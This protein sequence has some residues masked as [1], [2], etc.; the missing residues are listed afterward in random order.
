MMDT[1]IKDEDTEAFYNDIALPPFPLLDTVPRT[2]SDAA[3][4]AAYVSKVDFVVQNV[5]EAPGDSTTQQQGQFAGSSSSSSSTMA[6]QV[7]RTPPDSTGTPSYATNGSLT[8]TQSTSTSYSGSAAIPPAVSTAASL[9]QQRHLGNPLKQAS[10]MSSGAPRLQ[11][12][13]G[14]EAAGAAADASSGTYTA[15]LSG[16][17]SLQQ[18]QGIEDFSGRVGSFVP[19][20]AQSMPSAPPR[21]ALDNSNRL[22]A[23]RGYNSTESAAI[24][25]REASPFA[26]SQLQAMYLAARRKVFGRTAPWPEFYQLSSFER[27]ATGAVAV[28]RVE[29][30]VRFFFMNYVLLCSVLAVLAVIINPAILIVGAVFGGAAAAAGLHGGST[31][32]VGEGTVVPVK[33]IRYACV[34][35]G[36][37]T[38]LFVAGQLVIGL[39]AVCAVLVL[40]HA[41]L[42]VGV[43]YEKIAQHSADDIDCGV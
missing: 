42:H 38:L 15:D 28:D 8:P 25:R 4:S 20:A 37:L 13:P 12:A 33:N 11:L 36:L 40:L 29:R 3:S 7:N 18:Q 22:A 21:G 24:G 5:S 43:S 31:I 2:S 16:S 39:L 34:S 1:I 27:P 23:A 17:V 10:Y 9:Q 26:V 30:N 19:P 32:R 41:A 6:F 14:S 35:A